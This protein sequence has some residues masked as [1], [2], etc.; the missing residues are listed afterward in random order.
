MRV[1]RAVFIVLLL[2]TVS[3]PRLL[4]AS[5]HNIFID[6][7]APPD[8][9]S[10]G[11]DTD[12]SLILGEQGWYLNR[13]DRSR[14]LF[15]SRIID[16]ARTTFVMHAAAPG[17]ARV[18]LS[19]R[20]TD[21]DLTVR[22][23]ETES[24]RQMLD[25]RYESTGHI[26]EGEHAVSEGR[27]AGMAGE[28]KESAELQSGGGE[29][30]AT[31]KVKKLREPASAS[32]P[33]EAET[34][35]EREKAGTVSGEPSVPDNR[36]TRSRER[37]AAEEVSGTQRPDEEGRAAAPE[38]DEPWYFVDEENRVRTVERVSEENDYR[39][40]RRLYRNEQLE[41]AES[42]LA[43]YLSSCER[44]AHRD[45]ARLMLADIALR[46]EREEEGLALLDAVV[47]EGSGTLRTQALRIRA[48]EYFKRGRFIEAAQD[49]E[50]FYTDSEH[51]GSE[52]PK[53]LGDIYYSLDQKQQALRWYDR[54]VLEGTADDETVF[55]I[56]TIYDSPGSNRDIEKAYHY[57]KL[58]TDEYA[59]SVH[60]ERA[61]ERMRFFENNFF[62]YK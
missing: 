7:Q 17:D 15:K 13:Y 5:E 38:K 53:K 49:Y 26:D 50:Q 39:R 31:E 46:G 29:R 10:V 24:V 57:Y 45:S 40:G 36:E 48:E 56:A 59:S 61:R 1:V 35:L 22:I 6:V 30:Q 33:P 8:I 43:Q 51:E 14:L 37:S 3:L 58:L 41:E 47:E 44:C 27:H 9:V 42:H 19:F 62:N 18:L 12:F 52:I 25:D 21:I 20:G 54:S 34:R 2:M 60:V 32:K 4:P 23:G 11:I 16:M 55:R 28:R